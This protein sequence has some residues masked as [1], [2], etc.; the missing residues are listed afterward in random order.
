[1]HHLALILCGRISWKHPGFKQ[2][3]YILLAPVV[4]DWISWKLPVHCNR[5][6]KAASS[7][8]GRLRSD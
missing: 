7:C 3:V 1:M 2:A 8:T 4:C 5:F 6:A